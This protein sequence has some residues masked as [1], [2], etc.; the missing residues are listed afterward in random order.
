MGAEKEA[1]IEIKL[2]QVIVD[3]SQ[4][5]IELARFKTR[6]ELLLKG[7]RTLEIVAQLED[8]LMM[9]NSLASNRYNKPFKKDV[10]LWLG[11]L[12]TSGDIIEKWLFVQ[13]LWIYLEAVFVGG[14]IAAQ[15]PAE[16]ERFA[17]ID[18][19]Y[20]DLMTRAQQ[21]LNVV[22]ICTGDD[23]MSTMLPHLI[24]QLEA[25]QKSLTGYLEM[26]RLIFPRF[27]FVSD[28]VML[29][30]FGQA[31][32]PATIQPHLLSIFDAVATVDFE[33]GS[34]NTIVALNS[35]N[36]ENVRSICSLFRHRLFCLLS[37]CQIPLD[38]RVKCVGG[39]ELWLGYLLKEMTST[40]QSI[41]GQICSELFNADFNFIRDFQEYCGQVMYPFLCLSQPF[42]HMK[43]ICFRRV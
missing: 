38:N 12:N 27:F 36:G 19:N 37:A 7:D 3:W 23:T 10:L 9:L 6:G 5:N 15:L 32:N 22:D 26:K 39:V 31:S 4:V 17:T 40:V 35:D 1:D 28:P 42:E 2:N 24:E 11:K 14:D 16:A 20:V 25:C 43:S 33:E 29:E 21:V 18:K 13:S 8:S 41:L 30:I 34:S